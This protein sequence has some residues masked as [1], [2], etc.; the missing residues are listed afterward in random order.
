M[1]KF[2]GVMALA[3]FCFAA[4]AQAQ[5]SFPTSAVTVN[6]GSSTSGC[7]IA[8]TSLITDQNG[9]EIWVDINNSSRAARTSFTLRVTINGTNFSRVISDSTG[10]VASTG[11]GRV[12]I[13]RI[14]PALPSSLSNR[15]ATVTFVGCELG[16]SG[17]SGGGGGNPGRGGGRAM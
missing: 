4:P 15:S 1:F 16:G 17:S 6:Y 13:M 7:S 8:V 10:W 12:S 5:L 9:T 11:V 3:G 2:A 14:S